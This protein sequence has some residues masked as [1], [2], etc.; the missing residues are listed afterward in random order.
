MGGFSCDLDVVRLRMI[1]LDYRNQAFLALT[2]CGLTLSSPCVGA[3][4]APQTGSITVTSSPDVL[5]V[6]FRMIHGYVVLPGSIN[7]QSG[8]LILDTGAPTL[9]VNPS[10]FSLSSVSKMTTMVAPGGGPMPA[11]IGPAMLMIGARVQTKQ[12]G[13]ATIHVDDALFGSI[14]QLME[15]DLGEPVVAIVGRAVLESFEVIVDYKTSHVTFARLDS[16]GHRITPTSEFVSR[17]TIPMAPTKDGHARISATV[18]T[19]PL[20]LDL[21]TGS[22]DNLFDERFQDTLSSQFVGPIRDTAITFAGHTNGFVA[23]TMPPLVVGPDSAP[24]LIFTFQSN[25]SAAEPAIAGLI[26][27]PWLRHIGVIGFNFR[28]RTI[29]FYDART[30]R[31]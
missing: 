5:I 15:Q 25:V 7:G 16:A 23:A 3:A 9:V 27:T 6:P 20:W 11:P 2:L 29:V 21:D 24:G 28:A 1:L 4:Q 13:S 31:R 22:P 26:G 19:M 30:S 17:A 8:A 14:V 10:R 12:N 18:G